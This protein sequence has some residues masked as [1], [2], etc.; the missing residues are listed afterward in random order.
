MKIKDW[1]KQLKLKHMKQCWYQFDWSYVVLSIKGQNLCAIVAGV[2]QRYASS[3]TYST[4]ASIFLHLKTI[5]LS[6]FPTMFSSVLARSHTP[7][8]ELFG[9]K[10]LLWTLLRW[11]SELWRSAAS[12]WFVVDK[13]VWRLNNI[14]ILNN[15]DH[16][17]R[18]TFFF[19]EIG[20]QPKQLRL[21][22]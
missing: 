11:L 2:L 20:S 5:M 22:G 18:G 16:N 6:A 7:Q 19:C 1:N 17:H 14:K 9:V 12:R 8:T 3:F 10:P 21:N 13:R 15:Y 4:K